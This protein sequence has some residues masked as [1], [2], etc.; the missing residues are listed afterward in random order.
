M[1]D[2]KPNQTKPID[3]N[4]TIF[5]QSFFPCAFTQSL[6]YVKVSTIFKLGSAV[7][8]LKF[9][10]FYDVHCVKMK[11]FNLLDYLLIANEEKKR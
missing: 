4:S 3:V 11:E 7:L 2:I 6:P 10:F 1:L 8:N 9:S 5:D